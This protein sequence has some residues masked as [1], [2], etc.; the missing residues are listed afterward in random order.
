MEIEATEIR[1]V[2]ITRSTIFRDERGLFRELSR[3]SEAENST[4]KKFQVSQTNASISKWGT[5]R[6]MHF[7]L[8]PEGQWKWIT[9]LA[10]SVYDVVVDIRESSATF[11]KNIQI[12]LSEE[13]E[14]GLLIQG[15]LAHGFQ[16]LKANSIVTYNLSSEYNPSMEFEL[17]PLDPAL[18]ISWPINEKLISGKD[19]NAP[20]LET[21][22][23]SGMLP[24]N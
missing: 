7:S 1:G 15:N 19:L 4:G 22:R 3:F 8:H 11:S 9:C 18:G 2:W 5:V 17:N 12:E 23:T 16:A 21:L 24:L 6:G 13:N 14:L 10:G 20:S